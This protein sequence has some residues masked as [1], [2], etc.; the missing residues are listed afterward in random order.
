MWNLVSR[1]L[2]DLNRLVLLKPCDENW[3]NVFQI[4]NLIREEDTTMIFWVNVA[5]H[6]IPV[7]KNDKW[8]YIS[9]L[10]EILGNKHN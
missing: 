2:P 6:Y 1:K 10:D 5:D 7:N 8:I 4:V 3:I 9:E